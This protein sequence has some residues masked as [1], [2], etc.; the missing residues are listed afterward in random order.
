[1]KKV[2]DLAAWFDAGLLASDAIFDNT[3][4]VK[5]EDGTTYHFEFASCFTLLHPDFLT[6][7]EKSALAC[8][9][10]HDGADADDETPEL[11]E[12]APPIGR[13]E[14]GWLVVFTEHHG[15]H[16]FAR[17]DLDRYGQYKRI[18]VGDFIASPRA[19]PPRH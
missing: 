15:F 1:M 2:H 10:R 13:E 14:I 5:H 4:I 7:Y 17:G 12:A 11:T 16:V 19:S 6:D 8:W 9:D 3:V 18:E